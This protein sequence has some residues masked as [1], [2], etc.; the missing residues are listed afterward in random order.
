MNKILVFFHLVDNMKKNQHILRYILVFPEI[1]YLNSE[2]H[3][4][5]LWANARYKQEEIIKDLKKSSLQILECIEIT[6]SPEKVSNN[7]TR[8]YGVKLTDGSFKEVECGTGSFLLITLLDKN[9]K[10]EETKTSRGIER[11]N[12]NLFELK[13]RYREWTKGGHKIHATNSPSETN[14]DITLLLGKNYKD[15][16][17]TAPQAWNGEIKKIQRD[18]SGCN[19]WNNLQELF[20][21]LNATVNYV[22]LR[23]QEY[24]NS[25]KTKIDHEIDIDL[26][27]SEYD[28][29]AF[30]INGH[31]EINKRRPHYNTK[32]GNDYIYLDVWSDKNSYYDEN[33]Q[34]EFLAK[35]KLVSETYYELDDENKFY[36]LV[37]HS[38]IHKPQLK[39]LYY[40]NALELYNKIFNDF[41]RLKQY[42]QPFDLYCQLLAE[43]M[44]SHNY[45]FVRPKDETVFYNEILIRVSEDIKLLSEIFNI[46]NLHPFMVDKVGNSGYCYYTGEKNNK[47]VFI[48]S[49]GYGDSA[50]NEFEITQK[51]Y[52]L[53][54][55]NFLEPIAS[56]ISENHKFI[57]FDFV[58]GKSLGDLKKSLGSEQ[59]KDIV[60]QL[61]NIAH[62]LLKAKIVHRDIRPD[63]FILTKNNQLKLIDMQWAVRADDY[64][65]DVY[66][67]RH[68]ESFSY[69]GSNYALAQYCW[70]DMY[71]LNKMISELGENCPFITENLGKLRVQ[72][73]VRQEFINLKSTIFHNMNTNNESIDAEDF[74]TVE[75]ENIFQF[76]ILEHKY[77]KLIK[78]C[79]KY[80]RVIT[81][82]GF[83][84]IVVMMCFA[85]IQIDDIMM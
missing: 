80:K 22:V 10:Y 76:K 43:F 59:K 23:G 72:F 32:I 21:T 5:V 69:L 50:K 36:E 27:T 67:K 7:F 38:L 11:V 39:K 19:G 46:K 30:L 41:S 49:G 47:K 52:D 60:R 33:W 81:W 48:K 58:E 56:E 68:I 12:I 85:Y 75:N 53:N 31:P 4:M 79:S 42:S 25:P 61:E 40:T 63:N 83:S 66:V 8:F 20:Y 64:V 24:I 3:L 51:L 57:L 16:L 44:C 13:K 77:S 28:N 1:D 74:Q 45:K 14:H 73:D 71:S 65:E 6:W 34:K 29:L 78:K 15:Y 35:R 70:D 37:Y 82:L 54:H 9:P 2:L 84:L 55:E 26:F 18:L 17:K 62:S